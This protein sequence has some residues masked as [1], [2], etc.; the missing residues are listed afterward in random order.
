LFCGGGKDKKR[1]QKKS[2]ITH[3]G[4]VNRR[5]FFGHFYFRHLLYFI[6]KLKT[7]NEFGF[8]FKIILLVF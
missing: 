8:Q 5:R 6:N 4:H 2:H 1:K 3:S 7:K